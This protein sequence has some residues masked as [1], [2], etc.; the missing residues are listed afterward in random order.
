MDYGD[1]YTQAERALKF[2]FGKKFRAHTD[3]SNFYPSIYTHSIPWAL[4]G[5]EQAKKDKFKK[6]SWFNSIDYF[7]R[8][9]KRNETQG[10]GNWPRYVK[11]L[12]RNNL[13]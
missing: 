6:K 7:Q 5:F 12:F 3:I 9:L 2:G 8:M 10:I 4:V 11:Y 1:E 13:G